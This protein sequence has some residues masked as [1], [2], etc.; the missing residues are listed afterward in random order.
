M[1]KKGLWFLVFCLICEQALATVFTVIPTD[2]SKYYLGMVF[3]GSVGAISLSGDNNTT[4]SLMFERFNF[5]IVSIGAIVLSYLGIISTVNTAREGE[6]LGKKL[7]V[8]VPLRALGGML[9]MVPGPTSGYSLVQM[10]VLWIVLNGVG[11]ANSVW[12]VVL[13]QLAQN[14]SA[15]GG[16][17]IQL[18][19]ANLNS[20]TQY[21]LNASACMYS[22]NTYMPELANVTNSPFQ[23]FGPVRIYTTLQDPSPSPS[24]AANNPPG[25]ISQSAIVSVGLQGASPPF[26]TLCGYFTVK[27]VISQSDSLNNFNYATL[28][29]RLSIKIA[30]M[31]AIFNTL[32]P[33]AQLIASPLTSPQQYQEP[34]PGYVY[35]AGQAYIG[36]IAQLATGVKAAPSANALTWEV[37]S[38]PVNPLTGNYQTLQSYGWIHAGSYYYTMV[39]A[40]GASLDSE[41]VPSTAI[42]PSPTI[43]P[44]QITGS[45]TGSASAIKNGWL[46]NSPANNT[47]LTSLLTGT[48]QLTYLNTALQHANTYYIK[49][50]NAPSPPTQGIATSSPSTGNEFM[51]AIVGGI[52]S[53]IQDPILNY[54]QGIS[55]GSS[56]ISGGSGSGDPLLSIGQFGTTLML[57][58]ELAVFAALVTS[59]GLSLALSAGSCLSPFAW[60]INL[61]LVQLVPLVYGAAVMLWTAGATL[62]VYIPLIP[63]LIFT[64]SAFGWIIAV[65]EAIVGAP[66]IALGLTHP[67][68]EELGKL[69]SSLNILANLFLRPTLMIFGFVLGA[70]L[71]RAGIALINFGFIP[72]LTEATVPSIFSIIAVLTMYVFIIMSLVNKS[73]S[74]IY[75]LPNQIMRWM[76]GNA[77]TFEPGDMMKEAKAGFDTGAKYGQEGLQEGH[78]R[79]TDKSKA[80]MQKWKD[81]QKEKK[82]KPDLPKGKG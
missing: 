55:S 73:F 58:G 48:N 5:I 49:D 56:T 15:V 20:I 7:S 81:K 43:V 65:V 26:D 70:S 39:K 76:G 40:S 61:I 46:T 59:I 77:E 16:L 34:D 51:D 79:A 37:N 64:T 8:W 63:Y 36:Q 31:Q 33:A 54:I 69:G 29:Q 19:P 11:A 21:A 30:A 68:G 47:A 78:K 62:G 44:V 75:M 74:L 45:L 4:L 82:N 50:Q 6:A 24:A 32:D 71:L 12:N 22:I 57:A 53:A 25:Q 9:L 23:N 27:A 17:N 42:Y 66:I 13:G 28:T 1:I 3:G 38:A 14:V 67:S 52:A 10:T 35:A 18:K 2:R 60:G 72:A 80:D 41:T